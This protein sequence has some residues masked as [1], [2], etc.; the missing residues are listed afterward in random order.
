MFLIQNSGPW[1]GSLIPF[2]KQLSTK[3]SNVFTSE[4]VTN[5]R[6]INLGMF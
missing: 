5:L 4:K 1:N 2:H 3:F 6:Y